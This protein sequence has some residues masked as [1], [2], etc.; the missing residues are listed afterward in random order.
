MSENGGTGLR[1]EELIVEV[2]RQKTALEKAGTVPRFVDM[3]LG[4]YRTIQEYRA[5]LGELPEGFADYLERYELFGL[6]V[7]IEDVALPRV[8]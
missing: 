6:E 4:Q 8:R 1:A 5:R 3:T 2:Y 7:C